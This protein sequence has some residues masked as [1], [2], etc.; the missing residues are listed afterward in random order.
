[1]KLRFLSWTLVLS[2]L[3]LAPATALAQGGGEEKVDIC[4]V[5]GSAKNPEVS[6]RVGLPAVDAHMA[7]GDRMGPCGECNNEIPDD[8]EPCG[9]F[10]G[11]VCSDPAAVC[12]DDPRDTCDPATGADCPGICVIPTTDPTPD[13]C[14]AG[15]KWVDD[16]FD[17]CNPDCGDRDCR[18]ICVATDESPCGGFGGFR[19]M[20]PAFQDCADDVGDGCDV[21]CGGAD[22]IGTCVNLTLHPPLTCDADGCCPPPS[23]C[24]DGPGG[25]SFCVTPSSG[26]R[27]GGGD[28][29][30]DA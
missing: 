16:E 10:G 2:T 25:V 12:A 1:M 19:C 18:Q 8:I 20:D 24:L 9:G 5:T 4:H 28:D 27:G 14:P 3:L 29:D 23:I 22:C 15:F 30:G 11:F 21:D 17:D 7:H 13:V 6:I 26:D